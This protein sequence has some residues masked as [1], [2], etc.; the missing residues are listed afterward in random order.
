MRTIRLAADVLFL[1]AFLVAIY[2]G[3]YLVTMVMGQ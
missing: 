1:A 2:A 3:C